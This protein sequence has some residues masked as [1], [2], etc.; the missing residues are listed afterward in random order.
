MKE[1]ITNLHHHSQISGD[2]LPVY[3]IAQAG[4]SVGTDVII[5]TDRNVRLNG[6]D[7][8][9]YRSGKKL[10]LLAGEELIPPETPRE[11]HLLVI[12]AERELFRAASQKEWIRDANLSGAVSILAHPFDPD[13]PRTDW[14]ISGF[15]G[16]EIFNLYSAYKERKDSFLSEWYYRAHPETIPVSPDARAVAKW[17]SLL[18]TGLH[19]AA[20]AGSDGREKGFLPYEYCFRTLNNHLYM[21]ADLCGDLKT[22]QTNVLQALKAG[23]SFIGLDAVSP[24]EGF[25]FTAEGINRTAL[26]GEQ[27]PLGSSI[28][29]K[30]SLPRPALCR[31]IHNGKVLKQWEKLERMPLTVYETGYYRLEAYLPFAQELRGWIFSNPIY[32]TRGHE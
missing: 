9:F 2:G 16:I 3:D 23:R 18:S 11:N 25:R 26:P 15:T 19:V 4:L 1:I 13:A 29:L 20:F 24:T 30:I 14:E 7:Q 5:T 6:Q 17:D 22:D 21:E 8:Y 32:I 10:L 27:L 12:G 28:T 31:L